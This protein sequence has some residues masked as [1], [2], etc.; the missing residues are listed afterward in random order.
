MSKFKKTVITS[1]LLFS[2]TAFGSSLYVSHGIPTLLY[3]SVV[4][5]SLFPVHLLRNNFNRNATFLLIWFI[6]LTILSH[7][8]I[9]Q[10]GLPFSGNRVDL[11]IMNVVLKN[12]FVDMSFSSTKIS[13]LRVVFLNP[14]LSMVTGLSSIQTIRTANPLILS[15]VPPIIYYASLNLFDELVSKSGSILM[16]FSFS[17][18]FGM[19]THSRQATA[20]FFLSLLAVFYIRDRRNFRYFLT[21]LFVIIGIII[22]HYGTTYIAIAALA[23]A[24]IAQYLLRNIGLGGLGL[25]EYIPRKNMRVTYLILFIVL[26]ISWYIYTASSWPFNFLVGSIKTVVLG[27]VNIFVESQSP[28]RVSKVTSSYPSISYRL[29]KYSYL[30]V[31][32]LITIGYLKYLY[33]HGTSRQLI[34]SGSFLPIFALIVFDVPFGIFRSYIIAIIFL[35][36]FAFYAFSSVSSLSLSGSLYVCG[37]VLAVFL[38]IN[39][40]LFSAVIFNDIAR[41]PMLQSQQAINGDSPEQ[42]FHTYRV[43]D[44][45]TKIESTEWL[46]NYKK[47]L[48]VY[49]SD[50]PATPS[51][52]YVI[53]DRIVKGAK[54]YL[55][56]N[57]GRTP[58]RE[59]YI[60]IGRFTSETDLLVKSY[61]SNYDSAKFTSIN[62][63]VSSHHKIYSTPNNAVYF[64]NSNSQQ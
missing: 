20:L 54:E 33:D 6:S 18:F 35:A 16:I 3:A 1:I 38:L 12:S 10:S 36:P 49:G 26:T 14:I 63:S 13:T 40:G 22:S 55:D 59:S 5:I 47:S 19:V 43:F 8:L 34:I 42:K 51:P 48:P 60:Y 25:S 41:Y 58:D 21:F 44:S 29:I 15:L 57:S 27:L 39:M 46:L 2:I 4:S 53:N 52:K 24:Y 23:L 17:Y 62:D 56:Y 50:R 37:A 30:S 61:N 45:R 28:E 64:Y 32:G 9:L 7:Y 11:H 31:I